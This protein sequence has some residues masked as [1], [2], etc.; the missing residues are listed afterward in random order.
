M[1]GTGGSMKATERLATPV[2]K[3]GWLTA[4]L[5]FSFLAG[6]R[7]G[8]VTL[9]E[10]ATAPPPAVYTATL[11]ASSRC[12]NNLPAGEAVRVYEVTGLADGTLQWSAPTIIQSRADQ[13]SSLKVDGHA[14]SLVIGSGWS[15]PELEVFEGIW[16][17]LGGG[18]SLAIYGTGRGRFE[19]P[20]MSGT[21]EGDFESWND[22]GPVT[23]RAGNHHFTLVPR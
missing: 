13:K 15:D 5:L 11:S 14:V 23:C 21:F 20:E 16:E 3:P 2:G 4:A 12:A 8:A 9:P 7:D 1:G 18:G 10:S 17:G 6:C 19:G 22:N